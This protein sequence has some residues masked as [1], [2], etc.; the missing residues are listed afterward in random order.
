MVL[1]PHPDD[2]ATTAAGIIYKAVQRGE[3]VKVVFLTNGDLHGMSIGLGRDDEA[4]SALRDQ[5]GMSEN[6]TVFLGYP[7]GYM[8]VLY[9]NPSCANVTDICVGPIG[10]SA[11]YAQRGPGLTDYHSH[12]FGVPASYNRANVVADLQGI[13]A[14]F[15]PDHIFVTAPP[16]TH[17][18]HVAAYQFL[19]L[20]LVGL[21]P[22]YPSYNP[23]IHKT[24]VHAPVGAGSWPNALDPA[25]YFAEIANLSTYPGGLVWAER[26][27]LDVALPLQ[28]SQFYPGNSK[29]QA[30]ATHQIE[31]GLY[32]LIALFNHKDE[33][34]WTEQQRGTNQPP[35]VNAG[36]DQVANEGS[37]VQLDGSGSFD[38]NNDPLT[39]QWR[40]VA[41]PTVALSSLAAAQPTFTAPSGLGGNQTLAFELV[42]SDGTL[43]TLPDQVSVIV[44][45]PQEPTYVSNVAPLATVTASSE[46][47]GS[48]A[49]RAVDG[50]VDGFPG[51][52]TKEWATNGQG[53]GAW[54]QLNWSSPVTVGRVILYDRP[55]GSD[56]VLHGVLTFSDGSSVQVSPL[57][58]WGKDAAFTFSPRTI[59]S[60]RFDIDQVGPKT[61]SIGLS[62]LKVIAVSLAGTNHPP[63]AIAGPPQT[64]AEGVVVQLDGS[65]SFDPDLDPITYAW[66]QTGGPA[67]TLS[68]PTA[69]Q[70]TFTAPTGL[71]VNAAPTFNLVVNDGQASSSAAVVVVTVIA[72]NPQVATNIAPLST[73]TASSETPPGQLA[74]RAVDGIIDGYPGD[75]TKEWATNGEGVGA[76]LNLAW[77]ATYTVSRIV[78]YDRPNLADW[79]TGGTVSFTDGTSMTVGP[80]YNNGAATEYQIAG[81]SIRSLRLT[82]N[83]VSAG[84]ANV[85]LAEIQVYGFLVADDDADLVPNASDNCPTVPNPNQLDTD[86]DG[87]G[88][89]CDNCRT[90]VNPNQLD[91]D[92]DGFGDACDNCASVP[93]PS[94]SDVDHNGVGDLCDFNDGLIYIL[95]T[96]NPNRIGWQA[97]SG[98]TTWNVYE[99]DLNVLRATGTY[100]QVPGSNAVANRSCGVVD[101]FVDDANPVPAGTVRF[102][103][104]TGVAGGIESSLG[105]NSAG[106]AR[107]N[108]NPCP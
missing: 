92:H 54:I 65:A 1:A 107:P 98:F 8:D 35:V 104:V 20:A 26:E 64:V 30:I 87:V 56:W 106:G 18:D 51:D 7:D 80:L 53:A 10:I 74:I 16:D 24:I 72:S 101:L 34:S 15:Q 71:T 63:V 108:A 57:D 89:A 91:T 33:I 97:E 69:A 86:G 36:L 76:W 59:T 17:L 55:N 94:Q 5:L 60:L 19:S 90:V 66:T 3:A 14:S 81:K 102:S 52:S 37:L 49:I 68:S 12:Q 100:T 22:S 88:D 96:T 82:V 44:Q 28:S 43:T 31:G 13:L 62:E 70:P 11:T 85:G 67:V 58:N 25:A 73:V 78:L 32:S 6:D 103:L 29:Y 48:P 105:T 83:A 41:G 79:I 40:Q 38:R 99:G 42:V 77:P 23:T 27:S 2:D 4:V 9:S 46:V 21:F 45:S 47:A 95:G 39:Y 50:I 93:N 61:G 75:A 84:T